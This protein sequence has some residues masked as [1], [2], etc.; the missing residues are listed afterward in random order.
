MFARLFRL[1]LAL[2]NNE[3]LDVLLLNIPTADIL[4]DIE[5]RRRTFRRLILYFATLFVGVERRIRPPYSDVLA[6]RPPRPPRGVHHRISIEVVVVDEHLVVVRI[7]IE[8]CVHTAFAECRHLVDAGLV[9]AYYGCGNVVDGKPGRL[10]LPLAER[11]LFSR[12]SFSRAFFL[13]AL[14]LSKG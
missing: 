10:K 4:R 6:Q 14:L 13:R 9:V 8:E 5:F 3:S 11:F 1:F 7:R 2:L 12:A